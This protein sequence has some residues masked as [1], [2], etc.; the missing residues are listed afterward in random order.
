MVVVDFAPHDMTSLQ[1][2]HAH[3]WLGFDTAATGRYFDRVGLIPDPP[4]HLEGRPLTVSIWPAH[5]P[6]NDADDPN[7]A[8]QFAAAGETG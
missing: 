7:E 5:R 6:A 4:V 1:D 2:E 3:R 8:A